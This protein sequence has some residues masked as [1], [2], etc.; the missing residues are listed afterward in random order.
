MKIKFLLIGEGTSD[1]RLV[2]HIETIF[3]EEGFDEVSGEAPDL[4][5]FNPPVGRDISSKLKCLIKNF[6]EFD[7]IF[8]HRDAD[9][10]TIDARIQEIEDAITDLLPIEN[11]IPVIPVT[12]LETWLLADIETIKTIAGNKKFRAP[13]PNLPPPNR[14][15][16]VRNTKDLLLEI[17]CIISETQGARLQKFKK[18]FPEMRA[19]LTYELDTNGN[20]NDLPSYRTFRE[21]IHQLSSTKL[22]RNGNF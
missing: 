20:I 4:S 22:N 13:I 19:R 15:E 9:G 2:N 12:M 18:R 16:S 17:L 8:I 6:P 11:I 7:V 1:L 14:L 10:G 3:I 21:K 5:L